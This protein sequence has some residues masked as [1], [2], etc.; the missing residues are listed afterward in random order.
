MLGCYMHFCP[1]ISSKLVILEIFLL[2]PKK[3]WWIMR[4]EMSNIADCWNE[5]IKHEW[6]M[7]L[8]GIGRFC[9][10]VKEL[11]L[12]LLSHLLLLTCIISNI[13]RHYLDTIISMIPSFHYVPLNLAHPMLTLKYIWG[14]INIPKWYANQMS[15]RSKIT[16]L[17]I[18]CQ[19][20]IALY[21]LTPIS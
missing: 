4:C 8:Q 2:L 5:G 6:R 15:I 18:G 17:K 10:E 3:Y 11:S 16:N 12:I 13:L 7:K 14:K 9:F 21:P 20:N 19:I 1:R